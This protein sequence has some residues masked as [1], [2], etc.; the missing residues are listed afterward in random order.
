MKLKLLMIGLLCFICSP[1]L[2]A[3]R[4]PFEPVN[5]KQFRIEAG[6]LPTPE[7]II[8]PGNVPFEYRLQLIGIIWDPEKPLAI[9]NI[10]DQQRV[11]EPGTRIYNKKIITIAQDHI[12]LK[13]GNKTFIL[14]VGKPLII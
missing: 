4:D 2:Q 5:P 13:S 12:L 10:Q 11:V 3:M 8:G 14:K 7:S 9:L 6:S 1:H